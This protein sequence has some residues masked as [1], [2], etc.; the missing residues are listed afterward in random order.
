MAAQIGLLH[1]SESKL[2]SEQV[3]H[4]A[5][6]EGNIAV[7]VIDGKDVDVLDSRVVVVVVDIAVVVN[8]K[9]IPHHFVY[10]IPVWHLDSYT[11]E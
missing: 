8:D 4:I 7:A 3:H 5:V 1:N 11:S 10:T 2:E 9:G 6:A